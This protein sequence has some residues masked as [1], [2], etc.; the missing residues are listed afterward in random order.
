[1]ASELEVKIPLVGRASRAGETVEGGT[2]AIEGDARG[3]RAM[4]VLPEPGDAP[5]PGVVVIHEALGVTDDIRRIARRFADSGYAAVVPD[6]FD[7]LGPKPICILRTVRAYRQGGGRAL[8]ALEATRDW[9]GSHDLVDASRIGVAGFCMGGGFALLL[10]RR[11]GVGAAAAFYGDVPAH[12]EALAGVCPVVGS[13]GGQDRIFG[14]NGERLAAHLKQIGVR[15]D[16]KTYPEAGHSFMSWYGGINGLLGPLT[17]LRARYHEPSAED[18]WS[19]V[20]AFF[21]ANL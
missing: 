21:T 3:M 16:V 10:G 2:R 19:R 8:G 1:M 7:G 12:A 20:L 18:A 11:E 14:K 17:P 4:L 5:W 13:F 9:L 6:L 15:H